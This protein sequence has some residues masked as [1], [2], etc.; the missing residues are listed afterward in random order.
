[1]A[2]ISNEN[3]VNSYKETD[4]T[5]IYRQVYRLVET[6]TDLRKITDCTK[7]SINICTKKNR[8][9]DVSVKKLWESYSEDV[10]I[11]K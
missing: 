3:K 8:I 4:R 7:K 2:S 1:M 11:I 6:Y 9:N 5:E 10:N